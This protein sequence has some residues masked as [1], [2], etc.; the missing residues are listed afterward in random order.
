MFFFLRRRASKA[1]G[2][3]QRGNYPQGDAHSSNQGEAAARP[4]HELGK[5]PPQ[6][7]ELDAS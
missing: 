2:Y 3:G 4:V 5:N 7:L 1:S 6:A